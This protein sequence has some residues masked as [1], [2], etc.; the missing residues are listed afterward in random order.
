MPTGATR[1][2]QNEIIVLIDE[3]RYSKEYVTAVAEAGTTQI[4]VDS[5]RDFR[6]PFGSYMII[7]TLTVQ[8]NNASSWDLRD[9]IWRKLVKAG[10]QIEI[11]DVMAPGKPKLYRAH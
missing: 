11:G 9:L 2:L 1:R 8:R 6:T 10:L 7:A 5:V 4:S 3:N